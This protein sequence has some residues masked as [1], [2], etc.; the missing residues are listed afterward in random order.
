MCLL[1]IYGLTRVVDAKV[2]FDAFQHAI[3]ELLFRDRERPLPSSLVVMKGD[4]YRMTAG[5]IY[6]HNLVY[7]IETDPYTFFPEHKEW[8]LG[9]RWEFN[10]G[11]ERIEPAKDKWRFI[12]ETLSCEE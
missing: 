2:L 11:D 4:G 5:I 8:K 12:F 3:F 7:Y 9:P 1:L 6:S 10:C